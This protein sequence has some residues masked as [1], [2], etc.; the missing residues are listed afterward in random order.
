MA[1]QEEAVLAIEALGDHTQLWTLNRP[2]RRNA[3]NGALLNALNTQLDL[4]AE[5]P[6][7]RCVIVTGAGD[8][9]FSAGADLKERRTMK[10]AAVV[11]FVTQIGATF[12]RVAW[13]RPPFI[14]AISG[15]ALGGGL[16]LALACDLRA[17]DDSSSVGL[18]ETSLGIIPGAGG[19]QRLSRL[20]G[21]GRAKELIFSGRR[22]GAQEALDIGLA[23]LDGRDSSA[24][25]AAKRCAEQI[26]RNA[27]VAVA[28]AKLAVNRGSDLEMERALAHERRCYDRTISTQDRQEALAAFAE[29]RAPVFTGR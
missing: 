23:E 12:T 9:A 11:A 24:L 13:G 18:P 2:R 1:D 17:V 10:P 19:T 26:V 29:K 14:A 8:R 5:S 22:I 28:A 21:I 4:L 27:P 7:V 15:F 3:F 25:D 20:V 6:H 16:E